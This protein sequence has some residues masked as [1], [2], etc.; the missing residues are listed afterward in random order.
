MPRKSKQQ[1]TVATS[2]GQPYGIAGE[3]QAAMNIVPLPD[4]QIMPE[5]QNGAMP[6]T[7]SPLGAAPDSDLESNV[8]PLAGIIDAARNSP[9]PAA[10]AFSAPTERPEESIMARPPL[11]PT[12]PNN[13]ANIIRMIAQANGD[14]SL[15][16]IAANV[17]RLRY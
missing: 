3:Q 11:P 15:N 14:S 6:S 13:T 16:E 10:P 4:T 12:V 17:E 1:S 5:M 7:S 9:A 2:P 8:N